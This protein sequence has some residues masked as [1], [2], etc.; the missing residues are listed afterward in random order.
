MSEKRL[1]TLAYL[2]ALGIQAN[3]AI[4][5][6]AIPYS[7]LLDWVLDVSDILEAQKKRNLDPVVTIHGFCHSYKRHYRLVQDIFLRANRTPSY[8][9]YL[10]KSEEVQRYTRETATPVLTDPVL[11]VGSIT[12][13]KVVLGSA[14]IGARLKSR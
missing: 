1:K 11:R 3:P 2:D 6:D 9:R 5:W 10:V 12:K 14:L 8:G 4:V 7:F 13:L